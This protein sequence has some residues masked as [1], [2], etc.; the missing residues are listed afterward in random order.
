MRGVFMRWC[1]GHEVY[2]GRCG[3]EVMWWEVWS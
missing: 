3:H 2:G 1:G